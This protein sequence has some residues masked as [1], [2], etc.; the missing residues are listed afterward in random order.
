MRVPKLSA[1]D[2]L[3]SLLL[4]G[5]A[6]AA[7]NACGPAAPGG[8]PR[9]AVI[10]AAEGE[11]RLLRGTAPLY[12]KIDPVTTGSTRMIFGTSD[13]PPGDEIKVHRH[14][15]EDEIIYIVR[16]TA[17]VQLGKT[18]YMAVAGATVYIPQ[19]TCIAVA[20]AG[21][22]TLTNLWVFSSPGFEQVFRAVSTPAGTPGK[23]L[24]PAERAAAFHEGHAETAPA[25]C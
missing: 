25:D 15:R 22:D 7:A 3:V 16:G 2:R 17:R 11:R 8:K 10:A 13:L 19:G 24:T 20:N 14:L 5:A 18:E 4:A 6:L 1:R 12:I 21:T 9:P 23:V